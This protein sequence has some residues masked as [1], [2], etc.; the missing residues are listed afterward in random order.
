[1][2]LPFRDRSRL[3]CHVSL[4]S[5]TSFSFGA[6]VNLL[7]LDWLYTCTES[8]TALMVGFKVPLILHNAVGQTMGEYT[9]KKSGDPHLY[10]GTFE[11]DPSGLTEL[12]CVTVTQDKWAK[13]SILQDPEDVA[14]VSVAEARRLQRS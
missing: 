6:P 1:M 2:W 8:Y 4:F 9:L 5:L 10:P 13:W 11:L 3:L 14:S 7:S 12:Q